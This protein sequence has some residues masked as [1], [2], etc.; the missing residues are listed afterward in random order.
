[1]MVMIEANEALEKFTSSGE[2]CAAR[3]LED[4]VKYNQQKLWFWFTSELHLKVLTFLIAFSL[5]LFQ[6]CH[7]WSLTKSRTSGEHHV[8]MQLYNGFR[9]PI[10]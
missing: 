6:L 4:F 7:E 10:Y 5:I 1:M 2:D 3:K 9:F 8:R